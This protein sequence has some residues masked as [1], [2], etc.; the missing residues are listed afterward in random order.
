MFHEPLTHGMMILR[1]NMLFSVPNQTGLTFYLGEPSVAG[2]QAGLVN[3]A[4]FIAQCMKET[5]K[6]NACDENNWDIINGMYPLSNVCG[7]LGQS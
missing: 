2:T 4:A 3:I 1:T 7:Q 5:I 6:Y